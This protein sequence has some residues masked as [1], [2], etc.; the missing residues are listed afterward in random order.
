MRITTEVKNLP[1]TYYVKQKFPDLK[2]YTFVFRQYFKEITTEDE[3]KLSFIFKDKKELE[4]IILKLK[5]KDFEKLSFSFYE[6]FF[7]ILEKDDFK[8]FFKLRE[9]KR[10]HLY[11]F[12]KEVFIIEALN[13]DDELFFNYKKYLNS[14]IIEGEGYIFEAKDV[15]GINKII[16]EIKDKNKERSVFNKKYYG[17][18]YNDWTE[19][20]EDFSKKSIDIIK[21]YLGNKTRNEE[22]KQKILNL[23][24]IEEIKIKNLEKDINKFFKINEI[25]SSYKNI[26]SEINL[27]KHKNNKIYNNISKIN[28]EFSLI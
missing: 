22:S 15:S 26:I 6:N 18:D 13:N 8:I 5:N 12:E 2:N 1:N 28:S 17:V 16:K 3:E 20:F 23:F 25:K 24:N 4:D 21:N 27:E 10:E 11:I 9:I 7:R 14:F 19:D